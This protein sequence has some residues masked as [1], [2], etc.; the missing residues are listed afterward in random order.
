M[1]SIRVAAVLVSTLLL[2]VMTTLNTMNIDKTK[3]LRT[4][5]TM[6]LDKA[7]RAEVAH[8]KWLTNLS[9]ALYAGTE[10]T[11]SMDPTT[12][13]LGQWIYGNANTVDPEILALRDEA[14]PLHKELHASATKAL[15]LNKTDPV[16]ARE[17]FQNSISANLGTLIEKLDKVTERSA[18]LNEQAAQKMDST[19]IAMQIITG[20]CLVLALVCLI[21]LIVYITKKVVKPLIQITNSTRVLQ[22]GCLKLNMTYKSDDEVGELAHT[23]KTS[24]DLI[25]EYVADINRIMAELSSGNFNVRTYSDYIGDFH[26]IQ[27]SMA[28]FTDTMSNTLSSIQSAESRITSNAH[29]LSANSQSL[30]QG[31]TEQASATQQ[32]YASLDELYKS[33][34][35]NTETAAESKEHARLTGEQVAQSSQQMELM[36]NAMNDVSN[37]SQQ[38]EQIITTIENI[39]FQTNILA[40]NAAIEAARAGE[41]GKGFAVVA[42]EVR[43]LAAQSDQASKATKELIENSI[44]AADRGMTIVGEVSQTLRKTTELVTRSNDNI[45]MIADAVQ[46]EAEGITQINVGIGQIAEVTQTNTARSEEAAAVSAEL[47]SQAQLLHDQTEKFILKVTSKN[48]FTN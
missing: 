30:A 47:F 3:D 24:T 21:N 32:L 26:S 19:I 48:S 2:S 29:D 6:V 36:M 37:S 34:Q 12:C 31:A 1:V 39:A 41:A 40:L 17:Y 20:V 45:A 42:D 13:V 5:T 7:E 22:D 10:F 4:Q 27:T 28:S 44:N 15:E 18:A 14:E 33:A 46:N 38:I 8:Y 9:N 11:G 16:A 25:S 23:L 43:S 35:K